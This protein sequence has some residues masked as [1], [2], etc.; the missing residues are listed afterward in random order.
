M[1]LAGSPQVSHLV[2]QK[3]NQHVGWLSPSAL[4]PPRGGVSQGHACVFHTVRVWNLVVR[5]GSVP[6]C[7]ES[8]EAGICPLRG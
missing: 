7:K 3:P 4:F 5:A 2:V 6:L 8:L 1:I